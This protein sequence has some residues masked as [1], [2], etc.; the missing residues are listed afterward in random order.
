[1]RFKRKRNALFFCVTTFLFYACSPVNLFT[2]VRKTPEE[3]TKNYCCGDVSVPKSVGGRGPWIV[4]SDRDGNSTY[5]NPG[6]KVQMKVA[7]FMDPFVVIGEKGNYLRLVKYDSGIL[8]NGKWKNRD[9]AEYFGWMHKDN[10]LLSA[11]AT[12]DVATGASIK[13][14]TMVRDTTPFSRTKDFFSADSVVIFQEPELLNPIGKVPFQKPIFLAKRS[15]DKTKSLLVGKEETT[16]DGAK[17][18]VA[19]WVSSSLVMPLGELLYADFSEMPILDFSF[20][21]KGQQD[22]SLQKETVMQLYSSYLLPDLEGISPVYSIKNE[23]DDNAVIKTTLPVRMMDDSRN[24]VYSLSDEPITRG[25]YDDFCS[26]LQ[27]VNLMVVFSDQKMVCEKFEQIVSSLQSLNGIL[28]G[29]VS[30]CTFKMGYVVGF[31][32]NGGVDG[33]EF[34]LN[35]NI[36]SVLSSMETYADAKSRKKLVFREDAWRALKRALRLLSPYKSESN[37]VVLIGENGNV[38][39]QVDASLVNDLVDANCR[40][41]GCQLVSKQGNSFNNFVLQMEDMISRS[42]SRVSQKKKR[43]LV[44]S[45]QL[46][47]VNQYKEYSENVYALDFPKNSMTQGWIIFPKK[48]ENLSPDLLLSV[49]DSIVREVESDNEDVLS[50]IRSAFKNSGVGRTSLNPMWLRLG[51]VSETYAVK[52]LALQPMASL[53][54]TTNYPISLKTS[55]RDLKQGRY[56]LFLTESELSR[57]RGF[58]RD[59][60]SVRV[61]YKYSARGG[62]KKNRNK[63]CPDMFFDKGYSLSADSLQIR[64]YRNT[65]QARRSMRKAYLQWTRDE[66]VYPRRKREIRSFTLSQAQ[67]LVF[68]LPSF[69]NTLRSLRV[70]DLDDKDVLTDRQ[71][72]ELQEYFLEKGKDLE[73]SVV[74]ANKL[75]FNGETYYKID[76]DVLP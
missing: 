57:I 46:R 62:G 50:H 36:D 42:A 76:A 67:Q 13:M 63:S 11:H 73:S 52:P 2:K 32:G 58:L 25:Q 4:Y 6:G 65:S 24:L 23:G 70:R 68:T 29:S 19:G 60:T 12:T 31:D 75:V 7:S 26:N 45:E 16:P 66:K 27:K 21:S 61:D 48:K 8:E 3:Y 59:L 72:D 38:R 37:I 15:V 47:P 74:V 40:L 34:A 5:Y 64:E 43:L 30:G 18:M 14:I 33:G 28:K 20:S 51:G 69:N 53:R 55:I 56:V 39:E 44:H 17:T 1:M 22:F 54:P 71:L 41:V 49:T 9:M 35:A 10:L